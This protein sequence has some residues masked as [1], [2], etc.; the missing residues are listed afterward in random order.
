MTSALQATL[1][2]P[3]NVSNSLDEGDRTDSGRG[4]KFGP[5]GPCRWTFV[6]PNRAEAA[7]TPLLFP[8]FC[9]PQAAH[10]GEKTR[11]IMSLNGA[12]EGNRTLDN[13]LGK[14]MFYH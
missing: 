13:Q 2:H 3:S 14:L 1:N 4:R 7:K 12:G 5:I 9:G 11:I 8:L 10:R 6:G